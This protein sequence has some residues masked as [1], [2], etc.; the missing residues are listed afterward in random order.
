MV[1]EPEESPNEEAHDFTAFSKQLD[2]SFTGKNRGWSAIVKV[3][4]LTVMCAKSVIDLEREVIELR[5]EVR[6]RGQH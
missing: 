3:I 5:R 1:P 4:G 6:F 2:E